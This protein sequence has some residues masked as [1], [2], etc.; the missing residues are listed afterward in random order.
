MRKIFL[1]VSVFVL[2]H[3]SAA[4]ETASLPFYYYEPTHSYYLDSEAGNDEATGESPEQ[5]W[6]TIARLGRNNQ[7]AGTTVF[8]KRGG[9]WRET[10]Y[11]CNGVVYDAYGTGKKPILQLSVSR[12]QSTDWKP[13]GGNV[14]ET[15]SDK[16]AEMNDVGN[17]IFDHGKK[18]GFKRWE[19]N[20]LAENFD[21]WFDR[22]TK[23]VLLY[24]EQNPAQSFASIE[25]VVRGDN[26]IGAIIHTDIN[27]VIIRNLCIRYS[28]Y[29]I[30]GDHAKDVL[31]E[32][33][34]FSYIGGTWMGA[35]YSPNN[36]RSGNG[37]EWWDSASDYTVQRCRFSEI[38]DVALSPQGYANAG[39]FRNIIIR[40]CMIWNCEQAFEYWRKGSGAPTENVVFEHNTCVDAGYG[41][42]H[43]QQLYQGVDNACHFLSYNVSLADKVDITLRNNIFCKSANHGI[44]MFVDW[45]TGVKL[46]NNLW[47]QPPGENFLF[48][49]DGDKYKTEQ[50]NTYLS[51]FG[52]ETNSI[53]AE[54]EFVNPANRDYRLAPNSPG[55]NAAADGG[56]VG[57]RYPFRN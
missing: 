42:A 1:I 40:D 20:E 16:L 53:M 26:A 55:L 48:F 35:N 45:R 23:R 49:E 19:P 4:P 10:L 13:L 46:Y 27:K 29:G 57:A 25:L 2:Q 30:N 9:L 18:V 8:F 44:R 22:T 39:A 34:D 43:K 37:I 15:T 12:N 7:S 32:D 52:I 3:I 24:Y 50:F 17:I 33:C 56:M 21:F 41:W 31:V 6:K 38:Y 47:Y 36:V 51:E 11:P 14:W 5:A 28:S 54:P